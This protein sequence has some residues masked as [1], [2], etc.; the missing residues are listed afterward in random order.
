[1]TVVGSGQ[2]SHSHR[3]AT[4]TCRIP[5]AK[6]AQAPLYCTSSESSD[7]SIIRSFSLRAFMALGRRLLEIAS[8]V[9]S[10]EKLHV[11]SVGFVYS[12]CAYGPKMTHF[13]TKGEDPISSTSSTSGTYKVAIVPRVGLLDVPDVENVSKPSDQRKD[14]CQCPVCSPCS[15][16]TVHVSSQVGLLGPHA[17][18]C[19]D[20]LPY[21]AFN[22]LSARETGGG[23]ERKNRDFVN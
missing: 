11:K 10:K 21:C 9:S 20:C 13:E 1:M 12:V 2:I 19:Q 7:W 6:P 15:P 17:G 18:S 22:Q 14:C 3:V 23:G 16:R 5:T 4:Y 8:T